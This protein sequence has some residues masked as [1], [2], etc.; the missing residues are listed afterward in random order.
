MERLF[1][2]LAREIAKAMSRRDALRAAGRVLAGAV[3]ASA[4][5]RKLWAAI[6]PGGIGPS[7]P[8]DVTCSDCGTCQICDFD[9]QQCGLPCDDGCTAATLC[10]AA[11]LNDAYS[12]LRNHLIASR[13]RPADSGLEAVLSTDSRKYGNVFCLVISASA[14]YSDTPGGRMECRVTARTA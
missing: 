11:Q 8:A 7:T 10:N 5:G 6:A 14:V 9:A 4:S 12:A 1:D 13:F 2:N 3:L